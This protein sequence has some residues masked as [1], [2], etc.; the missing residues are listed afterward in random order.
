MRRELVA[1]VPSTA[2]NA[3]VMAF[4]ILLSSKPE[5]SPLR[6]MT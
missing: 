5:R 3:L 2:M 6:R 4:E 1:V